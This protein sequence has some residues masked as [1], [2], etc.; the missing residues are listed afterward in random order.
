MVETETKATT[1]APQVCTKSSK[2]KDATASKRNTL[3]VHIQTPTYQLLKQTRK[4]QIRIFYSVSPETNQLTIL[5]AKL[6]ILVIMSLLE[7]W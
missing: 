6:S 3:K 2:T 4:T 7:K 1:E 5:E